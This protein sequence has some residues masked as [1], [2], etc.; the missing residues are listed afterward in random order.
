MGQPRTGTPPLLSP[1]E[2]AER[3]PGQAARLDRDRMAYQSEAPHPSPCPNPAGVCFGEAA[4]TDR[5]DEIQRAPGSI[6][7]EISKNRP[8]SSVASTGR[9]AFIGSGGSVECFF[10]PGPD[11]PAN[12]V[13]PRMP[14]PPSPGGVSLFVSEAA[15]VRPDGDPPGAGR[16]C[17]EKIAEIAII[18][19]QSACYPCGVSWGSLKS[20]RLADFG[21]VE[22]QKCSTKRPAL[23]RR[24]FAF[25]QRVCGYPSIQARSWSTANLA[26]PDRRASRRAV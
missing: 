24:G 6:A 8:T 20:T 25:G 13:E 14:T 5:T 18:S 16:D 26:A 23:T 10:T 7:L 11:G 22:Y 21:A 17:L 2:P 4:E 3:L 1:R 12:R 19:V 9:S 15:A